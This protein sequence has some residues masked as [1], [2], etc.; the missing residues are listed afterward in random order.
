M[1][2]NVNFTSKIEKIIMKNSQNLALLAVPPAQF[3]ALQA[4]N[5]LKQVLSGYI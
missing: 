3:I 1:P 5:A 4:L 2:K